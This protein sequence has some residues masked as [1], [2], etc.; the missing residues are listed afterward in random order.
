MF[1]FLKR[2][3]L[4]IVARLI[5]SFLHVWLLVYQPKK[6]HGPVARV[7][8]IRVYDHE[9][10][11]IPILARTES[12]IRDLAAVSPKEINAALK[13]DSAQRIEFHFVPNFISERN[14]LEE[15]VIENTAD[16][17]CVQLSAVAQE[18]DTPKEDLGWDLTDE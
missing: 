8:M 9:D 3:A 1:E 15:A 4:S 13:D 18:P 7:S 2:R 16:K 11:V 17:L 5:R 14:R 10:H 6:K 12:R